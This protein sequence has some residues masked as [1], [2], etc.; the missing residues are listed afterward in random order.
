MSTLNVGPSQ[1]KI[2]SVSKPLSYIQHYMLHNVTKPSPPWQYN[3][4]LYHAWLHEVQFGK[5]SDRI[6]INLAY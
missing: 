3:T 1:I 4:G 2:N 6:E 5:M